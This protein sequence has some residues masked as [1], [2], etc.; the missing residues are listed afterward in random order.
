MMLPVEH[1]SHIVSLFGAYR[2]GRTYNILQEHA[3]G[4]NLMDYFEGITPPSSEED[5]LQFWSS[6]FKVIEPIKRIHELGG[7]VYKLPLLGERSKRLKDVRSHQNIKPSNI[8][9]TSG[10]TSSKY[11]RNF[12]LADL[13][14]SY[15]ASKTG[16]NR[17][18]KRKEAFGNPMYSKKFH[19]PKTSLIAETQ[20]VH[21]SVACVGC[22]R[23]PSHMIL[24]HL[25]TFG[26]LAAF[27]AKLLCGLF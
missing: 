6:L 18:L 3:D 26:H 16:D 7:Y 27:L 10:A 13:G 25:S 9:V 23:K 5:I 22:P 2:H 20:E 17:N 15:F 19:S 1:E 24:N 14:M 21:L 11:D 8:L 12:K 4:G